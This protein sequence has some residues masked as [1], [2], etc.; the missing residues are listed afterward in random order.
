MA[1]PSLDQN[2]LA[3][4]ARSTGYRSVKRYSH[5]CE[6]LFRDIPVSG[7]RVLDVGCGKGTFALWAAIN[8]AAHV[9][10]IEPE[11]SGSTTG[12]LHRFRDTVAVLELGKMVTARAE[13]LQ[14]L[15]P[16]DGP[17]DLVIMYNVINHLNEGAVISLHC[18]EG[19]YEQY[20]VILR[21]FRQLMRKG[22]YV[23]VAD[24]GRRNFWNDLGR[25]NPLVPT[26]EWH[27]HQQPDLWISLFRQAGFELHDLRWT[28]LYSLA[29]LTQN[30][31]AHYFTMSHFTL[32]FRAV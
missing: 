9:L 24:C 21:D 25:K 29:V 3:Y 14:G 2:M 22:G 17:F 13:Y 18:D 8:G 10:G 23:I 30:W 1:E 27:K 7:R 31:L 4:I 16:A 11:S 5:R 26:I 19:A 28:P 32:R 12:T 20:R 6:F 15:T